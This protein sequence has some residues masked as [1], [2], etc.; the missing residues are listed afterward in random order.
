[1]QGSELYAYPLDFADGMS[2]TKLKSIARATGAK[3]SSRSASLTHHPKPITHTCHEQARVTC[4]AKILVKAC[5]TWQAM[6]R[7]EDEGRALT[8]CSGLRPS[9]SG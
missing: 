1:M 7:M 2:K 3:A 8:Q 6:A 5:T 4:G 9:K